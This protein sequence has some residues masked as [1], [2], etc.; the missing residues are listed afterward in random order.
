MQDSPDK[1]HFLLQLALLVELGADPVV[2]VI[3]KR[4]RR[5]PSKVGIIDLLP[6]EMK[7]L[8]DLLVSRR[9]DILDDR[10]QQGGLSE[11]VGSAR[12][13]MAQLCSRREPT[14]GSRTDIVLPVQR[15]NNNPPHGVELEL[16]ASLL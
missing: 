16:V 4:L 13:S 10:H 7:H 6:V 11:Q 8:L 14:A 2:L 5:S 1:D 15:P 12:I 3:S 9:Q